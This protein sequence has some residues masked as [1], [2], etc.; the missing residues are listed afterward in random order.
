MELPPW[1][2]RILKSTRTVKVTLEFI[3]PMRLPAGSQILRKRFPSG[4]PLKKILS[5]AGY[6]I[7]EMKAMQVITGNKLLDL[8]K[9]LV[10]N[11]ELKVFLRLGGG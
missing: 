10:T 3:G 7:P 8:E 2:E 11:A 1:S 9:K 4:T 6:S 5:S